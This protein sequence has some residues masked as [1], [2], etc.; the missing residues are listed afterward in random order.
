MDTVW[1]NN[2]IRNAQTPAYARMVAALNRDRDRVAQGG[3]FP[4]FPGWETMREMDRCVNVRVR[5]SYLDVERFRQQ[6]TE[7]DLGEGPHRVVLSNPG[8]NPNSLPAANHPD[9]E[10]EV[11]RLREKGKKGSGKDSEPPWRRQDDRSRSSGYDQQNT[12][13]SNYNAAPRRNEPGSSSGHESDWYLS[14]AGWVDRNE[15][16]R[17]TEGSWDDLSQN[18]DWW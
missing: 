1:R 17:P 8:S 4:R 3:I 10:S 6:Q 12:D 9:Y 13:W 14:R 2:L 11:R 5:P 18:N 15:R 16:A 7:R